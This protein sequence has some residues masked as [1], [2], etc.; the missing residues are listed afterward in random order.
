MNSSTPEAAEGTGELLLKVEQQVAYLALNRPQ[1][2]NALHTELIR[3]LCTT[4]EALQ[5][6]DAVRVLV[7][8]GM[9]RAFC[10]G[11]DLRDP[12]MAIDLPAEQR[13]MRFLQTADTSIHALARLLRNFSKPIVAAVNGP[14][15]GGGAALAFAA[16]ITIAG[17][18]AY[19]QQP[20][21]AQLGLVPDM[22]A[23]WYLMRRAGPAR[24]LGLTLLGDRLDAERAAQ[25][26]L[27]WQCVEDDTLQETAQN[28]A[29]QL[30]ASAPRAMKALPRVMWQALVHD[31]DVQLDLERDTQAELVQSE[32]FIEAVTAF[33]QKRP[34]K[35]TGR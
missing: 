27:I 4:L 10:V 7:L 26:G 31:F 20:F 23:S 9:G 33:R 24:A 2:L 35:F 22:G 19:F 28:I 12:M 18:S 17:R 34:P 11:A 25:W 3:A 8:T 14:A 6:D 21:S 13:G 15:V 32:D 1:V 30:A 5:T 29:R 16:D